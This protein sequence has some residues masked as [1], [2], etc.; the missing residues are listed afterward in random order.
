[1][2]DQEK[3][4]VEINGVKMEVDLRHAKRID[5]FKIG[6]PVKLLIVSDNSVKAGVIVGFEAFEKLPTIVVVWIDDSYYSGGLKT[7]HINEKSADKYELVACNDGTLM[8]LSRSHITEKL[9]K[10]ITKAESELADARAQLK[11]FNER[12]GVHFGEAK[13]C[14]DANGMEIDLGEIDAALLQE[15]MR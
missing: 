10:A 4:I 12:F 8:H 15:Q 1:M 9:E 5:T 3:Q 6:D 14:F 11:Y 13:K 2:T 7:A